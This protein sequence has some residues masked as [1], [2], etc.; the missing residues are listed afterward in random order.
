MI[1]HNDKVIYFKARKELSIIKY[2]PKPYRETPNPYIG[3]LNLETYRDEDGIAKAYTLGFIILGG[4][5]KLR[6]IT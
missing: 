5:V 3:S 2:R 4:G 6:L 1:I